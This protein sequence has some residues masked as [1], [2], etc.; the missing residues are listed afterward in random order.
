MKKI[1]RQKSLQRQKPLRKVLIALAIFFSLAAIVACILSSGAVSSDEPQEISAALGVWSVT[2]LFIAVTLALITKD[3]LISV[4]LAEAVA[5]LMLSIVRSGSISVFLFFD[6]FDSL[7]RTAEDSVSGDFNVDILLMILCTCGMIEVVNKSGGFSALAGIIT[8]R[9]RTPKSVNLIALALGG[10]VSFDDYSGVLIAGPIMKPIADRLRVSRE[11]LAFIVDATAAPCSAIMLISTWVSTEI[12][13]IE[14]SLNTCGIEGSAYMYFIRS[15]PYAFYSILCLIFIFFGGITGR[16]YGPMLTAE[17]IARKRLPYRAAESEA[18]K[19]DTEINAAESGADK[20]NAEINA[21]ASG[22]DKNDPKINAA[23]GK[24]GGGQEPS[25]RHSLLLLVLPI[26]IFILYILFGFIVSGAG[27]MEQAQGSVLK[28]FTLENISRL[29]GCADTGVIMFQAAVLSSIAAIAI[30]VIRRRQSLPEAINTWISG[31]SGAMFT[32][33]L[34]ALTW[35]FAATIEGLGT[36]EYIVSMITHT[37]SFQ[38]LPLLIFL[39]CCIIGFSVGSIGTMFIAMPIAIPAAYEFIRLG[40]TDRPDAYISIAIA[41]VL[42]GALFGD[43]CS[44]IS[45]TTIMSSQACGCTNTDHVKT[46]MPYA[47]T[48]A[49]ASSAA[50]IITGMDLPLPLAFGAGIALIFGAIMILGK[51]PETFI[52]LSE[53]PVKKR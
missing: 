14:T 40:V 23:G 18:G 24:S 12:L 33:V 36:C 25:H 13:A 46:Q 19:N 42:S 51:K 38:A 39:A 47:L 17:I 10:I 6:W 11:K 21:T 2:P 26:A 4:F 35:S 9:V 32:A 53:K 30:N 15:I 37:F 49:A 8:K 29:L 20:N 48:V 41:C 27:N 28:D 44:P 45:D 52:D 5:V 31:L 16:E 34:L 1:H 50:C 22:A 3:V 7:T 43:H